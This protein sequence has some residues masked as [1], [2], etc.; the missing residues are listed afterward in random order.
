MESGGGDRDLEDDERSFFSGSFQ[1]KSELL[2]INVE[3]A[4]I[5]ISV[6]L[7]HMS[8]LQTGRSL[9]YLLLFPQA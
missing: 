7:L 9:A 6:S 5:R 3:V 2:S 8:I 4:L 1:S